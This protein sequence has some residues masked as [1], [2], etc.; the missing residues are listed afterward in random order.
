MRKQYIFLKNVDKEDWMEIMT[1]YL[2]RIF[3][4]NNM[5]AETERQRRTAGAELARRRRGIKKQKKPTRPFGS[6]SM[7]ELREFSSKR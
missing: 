1:V 3:V 6:I 7:K 4:I 5:P 2:V